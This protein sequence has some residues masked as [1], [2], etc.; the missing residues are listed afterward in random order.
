M[1]KKKLWA[2]CIALVLAVQT[3]VSVTAN[4]N[5]ALPIEAIFDYITQK[6]GAESFYDGL[7]AGEADWYAFCRARLY[8]AE[9]GCEEFVKSVEQKAQLLVESTGFVP[10]TD[11]QRTALLLSAFGRENSEL[12]NAA[13][14]FNENLD[15]QGLNAYIWALI[16]A[17]GREL[18]ENAVNTPDV[19]IEK[20]LSA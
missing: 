14:Y 17:T 11:L 16:A 9:S 1:I 5:T 7:E 15:R 13:V 19:L 8:G 20:L 12:L 3:A 10:P 18:P 6:R 2:V 4:A